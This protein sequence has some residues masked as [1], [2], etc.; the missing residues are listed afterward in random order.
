MVYYVFVIVPLLVAGLL[1]FFPDPE[2]GGFF[3]MLGAIEVGA[4]PEAVFT[5]IVTTVIMAAL[6]EKFRRPLW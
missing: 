3:A 5:T 1:V 2:Y 6:P 4:L